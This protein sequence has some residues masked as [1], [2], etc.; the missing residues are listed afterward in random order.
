LDNWECFQWGLKAWEPSTV[1]VW[2]KPGSLDSW[3][4]DNLASTVVLISVIGCIYSVSLHTL[5]V[6]VYPWCYSES[7]LAAHRQMTSNINFFCRRKD[8]HQFSKEPTVTFLHSRI[9]HKW[10]VDDGTADWFIGLCSI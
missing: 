5:L 6:L 4:L 8:H 3:G 2:I 10:I 9:L 7:I 1:L